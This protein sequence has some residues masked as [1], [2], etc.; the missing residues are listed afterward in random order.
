LLTGIT[1]QP[2]LQKVI[3]PLF[4]ILR[5]LPKSAKFADKSAFKAY[6]FL[7]GLRYAH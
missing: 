7:A 1:A 6:N 3:S 2:P 4:E 5:N